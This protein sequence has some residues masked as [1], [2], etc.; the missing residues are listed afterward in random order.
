MALTVKDRAKIEVLLKLGYSRRK[1]A[2]E[3]SVAPSTISR[4]LRKTGSNYE[5]SNAHALARIRLAKRRARKFKIQ[6]SL[7]TK[8]RTKLLLDWSPEQIVGEMKH[9]EV[10]QISVAS[11]YRFIERDQIDG[12]RLKDHLRI[13]R[14]QRKDRKCPKW[15]KY[16]GSM[17]DRT[18]INE[19]PKLVEKRTRLGDIERDTVFGVKNGPL[20][21]TMVDRCSRYTYVAWVEKKCSHLIHLATVRKLKNQVVRTITND[22]GTE[23]ARHKETAKALQADIY[24]SKAYAAWE[25]GTNENTNGLLRQYFPRKRDIGRLTPKQEREIEK[26]LNSRP[27]KCLNF[28]TPRDVHMELSR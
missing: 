21:L 8:I 16:Q 13:L 6:G 24:F 4:E 10:K 14:R 3:L 2:S 9:N 23:F 19:R 17:R 27:R 25:R 18:S 5:S 26:K 1:I 11:I 15:R 20:L 22:N 7:A 12:G 28:R